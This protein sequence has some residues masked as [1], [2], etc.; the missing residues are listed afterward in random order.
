MGD[1]V[2]ELQTARYKVIK[3]KPFS[4]AEIPQRLLLNLISFSNLQVK[5]KSLQNYRNFH[6]ELCRGE[7]FSCLFPSCCDSSWIY[8]SA[9][10]INIW[11]VLFTFSNLLIRIQIQ[12]FLP[13][14]LSPSWNRLFMV[15]KCFSP[16]LAIIQNQMGR[17]PKNN[18]KPAIFIRTQYC[19][20][21][22]ALFKLAELCVLLNI[23]K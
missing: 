13:L 3:L 19:T 11:V 7:D 9:D 10:R 2:F 17:K 6:K 22:N 18:R 4:S 20:T 1:S 12:F 23:C 14:P 16:K 21:Q 8:F 15:T 5:R